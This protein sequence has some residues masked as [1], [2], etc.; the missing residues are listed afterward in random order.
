MHERKGVLDHVAR[1]QI[2][3]AARV[4]AAVDGILRAA[5]GMVQVRVDCENVADEPRARLLDGPLDGAVRA[6]HV[7]RLKRDVP[8]AADVADLLEARERSPQ[9]SDFPEP[10][11][12][13]TMACGPDDARSIWNMPCSD[14]PMPFVGE[15]TSQLRTMVR[16]MSGSLSRPCRCSKLMDGMSAKS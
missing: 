11:V 5:V 6:E 1:Q 7:A 13:A 2:G 3:D 16:H 9:S 10:V 15:R 4:G 8:G 12:P 14:M